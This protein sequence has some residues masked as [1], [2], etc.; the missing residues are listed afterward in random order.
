MDLPWLITHSERAQNE[1][2]KEPIFESGG[3]L[4]NLGLACGVYTVDEEFRM[5]LVNT[6]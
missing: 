6:P 3:L 2:L 4:G 1:G 5:V